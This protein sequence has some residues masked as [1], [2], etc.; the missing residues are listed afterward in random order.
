MEITA[1]IA[2]RML[3]FWKSPPETALYISSGIVFVLKGMFPASIRVAPNSPR[4]LAKERISAA[5]IPF[6]ASGR[7]ILRK[8]WSSP[9]PRV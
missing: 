3:A 7:T 6:F 9:F 2:V 8:V 4:A 1:V 5:T